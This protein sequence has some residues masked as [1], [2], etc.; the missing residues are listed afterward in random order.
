[1]KQLLVFGLILL[2]VAGFTFLA[3]NCHHNTAAPKEK[4]DTV[5]VAYKVGGSGW[6]LNMAIRKQYYGRKFLSDSGLDAKIDYI[7]AFRL[8]INPVKSDSVYDSINHALLKVNPRYMPDYLPDT[9]SHYI[10][11]LDSTSL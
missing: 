7:S 8:K 5:V 3:V 1:M 4:I 10:H 9:L 6:Q 11:V 2:A